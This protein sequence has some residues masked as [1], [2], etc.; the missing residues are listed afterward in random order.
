MST[1]SFHVRPSHQLALQGESY[2]SVYLSIVLAEDAK[3]ATRKMSSPLSVIKIVQPISKTFLDSIPM[4]E[5]VLVQISAILATSTCAVMV[6]TVIL[7]ST[8]VR[9][10]QT[11]ED[12]VKVTDRVNLMMVLV[13][14]MPICTP[15][16]L[17]SYT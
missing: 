1:K 10:D 4:L 15:T 6:Q 5:L 13:I 3:E 9:L 11:V 12:L 7:H 16:A 17:V 8:S 2:L 14:H